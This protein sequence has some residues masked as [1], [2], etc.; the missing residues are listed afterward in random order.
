M[1]SPY[2]SG[3]Y[4]SKIF[5][6]M[7]LTLF[8]ILLNVLSVYANE[9][10]SQNFT[11]D[12]KNTSIKQVLEDIKKQSTLEFFYSNDDFDTSIEIDITIKN[13]SLEKVLEEILPSDMQ[14]RLVDNTVIISKVKSVKA[15][16]QPNQQNIIKGKI[17][18]K[19]GKPLPGVTIT[20]VGTTRGVITDNDGV[21]SIEANPNDKLVFSFIG[22]ES[23]IIDVGNQL[24]INVEMVEKV[25]EL[26]EVTVVA[27]GKQRKESVVASISSVKPTDLKIPSSNLTTALAG[28]ISGLI[29]YQRSGEPGE[30]FAEFFIRGITTFGYKKDPLIL[31]DN[32][33]VTSRE[34]SVLNTDDIASF[35]IM[36]DATATALYG[37]R[38][39]NGVILVTTKGGIEGPAQINLRFEESI[40]M[41]TSMVEHAD[42]ITYMRL[43][44]E[45]VKT[46]DP[47]G[48][49][50]YTQNKIDHTING[51]NPFVYPANDWYDLLF[52]DYA[53]NHRLNVNVRGGGKN[54][55][56]Y[57]AGSVS[58]DDGI[59]KVDKKNNFNN[60]ID[61]RRYIM[62]SNVNIDIT[63]TTEAVV[64][65]HGAFD[66]YEGPIDG[67]SH[68]FNMVMQTNPVLFPSYFEPDEDNIHTK[69][70]LFGNYDEGQYNNPY[71]EMTKGYKNYHSSTMSAQFELNQD[72][73]FI[74][75]G[76]SLR[77]LFNTNRYAFADVRRFYNPYY[78]R[79]MTYDKTEDKYTL[80]NINQESGTE[81]LE[82]DEGTKDVNSTTYFEA[83]LDWNRVFDEKHALTGL[84]VYTVREQLVSNAGDLQ[85]SLPYRNLNL[86]G[87]LTYAYDFRY[88]TEFNFGYNGSERFSEKERFGFF[89]SV[90]LGWHVS[91]E[92]F[93]TESLKN[94]INL[95]KIKC[96]YG[97]VGNDAIGSA[98]DRFFY[99]SNINMSDDS[100][101]ASF[102]TFGNRGGYSRNGVSISRYANGDITWETAEKWNFGVEVGLFDKLDIQADLFSEYRTN[103]LMTRASIPSTMGLQSAIR[104]N[105]GEASSKGFEISA[106]YNYISQNQNF[107]LSGLAN[108]TYATSQFEVYE[109]PDYSDTPWL[110]RIGYS[111]NQQWGYVAQRLFVDD[112]EVRNSPEQFGDYKGGDI[113]FKDINGDGRIT[114]LDRVP[115]GYPTVPEILYGFGL[116]GGIKQFDISFFLQGTSRTSF[117]INPTSTAPFINRENALIKAYADNH[118]SEDNRNLFALWPRLSETYITNNQQTSTWF[119]RDGTFLR[120]KSLE[121]GYTLPK[122]L[123]SQVGVKSFRIYYSGINLLTFSKFKLWDPE[124]GGNGLSYPIQ[125]VHNLGL[126]LSF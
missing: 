65:L 124:M 30:D 116:S 51:T 44:N 14:Y 28:R 62:R 58:K 20:V 45:A 50:H 53:N 11:L 104:A 26:E 85:R 103:I 4:L 122:A 48:L 83:A 97:F 120:L 42:P 99:L 37:A 56:Y 23:Q 76:L 7:K 61:L 63:N 92:N 77:G 36:K 60:N 75:E 40:S 41:P 105:V 108:F 125:K 109:E 8:L 12:Y 94:S 49:T 93:W 66:Q 112:E 2:K 123:L 1:Y 119:M 100:R 9:T 32:N 31:I 111:L 89:P 6:C 74:T 86:A 102:G 126:Q 91:N 117:W 121:F 82:Y 101:S 29:S 87:R 10:Y 70:I 110:S 106:N 59:L 22:M 95:F 78:Y 114:S 113:K 68:Y 90:G 21:Y 118:W 79:V 107:W 69:H 13:G 33:E 18:D 46:R 115:I 24:T 55:R 43:H 38:G 98:Y 80:Y 72:L 96:T 47:L 19:E 5:L 3:S 25:D 17:T 64:R 84:L 73:D 81:Y 71:A 52:K 39:A 35:S 88:F 15:A 54:V 67:G 16:P 34:L 27:F 57:L